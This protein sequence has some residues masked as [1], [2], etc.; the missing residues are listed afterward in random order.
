MEFRWVVFLVL[1][2]T[3]SGPI[4]AR[5]SV[6]HRAEVRV[7]QDPVVHEQSPTEAISPPLSC[8]P[9]GLP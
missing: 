9:N 5:P 2:T 7:E 8:Q 6:N 4:L 1:W 3:F